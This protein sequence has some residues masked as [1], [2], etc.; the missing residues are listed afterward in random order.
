MTNSQ[1]KFLTIAWLATIP[2]FC[3]WLGN[4]FGSPT[5]ITGLAAVGLWLA[6]SLAYIR[7]SFWLVFEAF[8][9]KRKK[10]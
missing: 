2:F 6:G 9:P 8:D 10:S 7:G 3:I 4:L 1:I 5:G